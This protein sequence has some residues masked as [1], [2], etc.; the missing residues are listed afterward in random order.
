VRVAVLGVGNELAGDDGVGVAVVRALQARLELNPLILWGT[1]EADL[2]EVAD[3]LPRAQR[4]I[5]VDAVVGNPPGQIVRGVRGERAWA[6][7]FHQ[8]DLATTI[9]ILQRMDVADPFPAW[10]IWG[11]TI[12]PPRELGIGLSPPVAAAARDMEER[13]AAELE[14]LLAQSVHSA[15]G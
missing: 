15:P 9:E 8:T 13:L 2:L 1:L 14:A 7:S 10:E 11:V 5:F 4:F 6:P 12:L 3:W